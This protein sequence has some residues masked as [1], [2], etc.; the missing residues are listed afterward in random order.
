MTDITIA[1]FEEIYTNELNNTNHHTGR[2]KDLIEKFDKVNHQM[3]KLST[4][5]DVEVDHTPRSS[6]TP[7]TSPRECDSQSIKDMLEETNRL[8]ESTI[9]TNKKTIDM[10]KEAN[11]LHESTTQTYAYMAHTN[12]KM[13]EMF[14]QAKTLMV[15]LLVLTWTLLI[16][17][18]YNDCAQMNFEKLG[19]QL[20][21]HTI[22]IMHHTFGWPYYQ[23]T[24][25]PPITID[26]NE[27][28]AL[29]TTGSSTEE[30]SYY[31]SML[32]YMAMITPFGLYYGTRAHS[33]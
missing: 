32:H 19:T 3:F 4:G 27:W 24:T 1:Q 13:F 30:L 21:Q 7:L 8:N 6:N 31:E 18:W 20:W 17:A 10:L 26:P 9:Q 15:F 28:H 23:E 29:Y 14:D 25:L 5:G 33:S 16:Y 11:R 2:A 22:Q 12:L